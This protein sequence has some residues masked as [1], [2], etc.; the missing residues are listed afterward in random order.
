LHTH[1]HGADKG[2]VLVWSLLL[3]VAF[4]AVES[5]AGL[6]AGSLAL[7]ADAGHNFTDALALA[8]AW[9]GVYFSRKPPDEVKTFGYH[10]AGVLAAFV[11]ALVLIAL[12]GFIFWE[13]W[14]RWQ[15][16]KPVR[17]FMMIAVAAAGL[18]VN[19]LIMWGLR[20]ERSHDVNIR[21]AWLHM[22]GDAL[23][24]IGIIGGAIA[25]AFTGYVR[26]DPL[27]SAFIAA[28][29]VWTAWDVVKETLN[30][31]LEGLPRGMDFGDVAE[32]IRRVDG[33]LDVHDL[34][35]WSLGSRTHALSCHALIE[36]MP[37]SASEA[38]LQRMNDML[39]E[40]F[41]IW[42]TTVQFENSNC[43]GC[44]IPAAN[45]RHDRELR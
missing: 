5:L 2:T 9:L 33:V 42:H 29:I 6:F 43:P 11:N 4:V 44:P 7:L 39:G 17:E 30:I 22:L 36:D 14:Q 21:S 35:I 10:R 13:S 18:F 41:G 31:L 40:R 38:I 23:G 24:S 27:L 28:L 3:T 20:S 12:S 32:A 25:I 26:V 19:L 1:R 15:S 45:H 8:L 16:P 34:H 37:P